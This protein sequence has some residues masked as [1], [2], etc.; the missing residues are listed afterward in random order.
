MAD[1]FVLDNTE[2]DGY[3]YM[4]GTWLRCYRSKNL[5]D[6]EAVPDNNILQSI[7]E[8]VFDGADVIAEDVWAPEIVY[9][10]DTKLYYMFFSATPEARSLSS[11]AIYQLFVATSKYPHK[12]FQLVNFSDEASCGDGNTHSIGSA[13]PQYYANYVFLEPSWYNNF[14]QKTGGTGQS[15]HANYANAIDPHPFVDANGD[16]Y[17]YWVDNSGRNSICVVKMENWLKPHQNTVAKITY[18]TYYTVEDWEKANAGQSV[19]KVSYESENNM[20]NEAPVVVRHNGKYY[21][22]FSVN[23]YKDNTYQVGQAVADSPMGPFRKLTEEEGGLL[24]SGAVAGSQEITGTGHHCFVVAGGH[25]YIIYHRHDDITVSPDPRNSAIDEVK[26]VTVKDIEKKSLEVMYVNG[27]T[28]TVQPSLEAFSKYRNLA[29]EAKVYGSGEVACLTDGLLSINKN[30]NKTFQNYVPETT[31][32]GKTTFTFDFDTVRTVRALMVYNS[33]EES[34]AFR[35][36]FRIEFVCESEGR[37]M[38][39]YID[40]LIFRDEYYEEDEN[41]VSYVIPGAAACAKFEELY[42][43]SIRIT[44]DVPKGQQSVGLSEV[45]I[46]GK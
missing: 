23:T 20:V 24:L 38:V 27:P 39:R 36:I 16:K 17:L 32:T 40:N 19:K 18:A 37:E 6:W 28:C 33:K 1:P 12:D 11:S 5:M 45:R 30:G 22:T 44:V 26:W 10:G 13:Y 21:L 14:S 8:S 31:I 2:R 9:D 15:G 43:K 41:G 42:V 25:R 4:Y 34:A 3:Y 46:L 35:N 7:R 29:G